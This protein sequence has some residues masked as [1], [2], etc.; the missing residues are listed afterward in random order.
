MRCIPVNS[1]ESALTLAAEGLQ[2][3]VAVLD[4]HMP[5]MDGLELGDALQRIPNTS[6]PSLILLT[7]LGWRPTGLEMSFAAF[8]TKSTKSAVLQDTLIKAL[9]WRP[10]TN[11]PAAAGSQQPEI[12]SRPLQVL[13][14]E[15]NPANQRV[16]QLRSWRL[17]KDG[18]WT[19]SG[20]RCVGWL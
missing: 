13:L 14:A 7:S 5:N 18:S 20:L 1:P 10:D 4:T 19:R 17:C 6:N 2:Y 9:G 11:Q 15:D 3:D 8:L 12:P 16:A